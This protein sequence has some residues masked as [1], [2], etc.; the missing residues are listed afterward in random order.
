MN[1]IKN[2]II[3]ESNYDHNICLFKM[4]NSWIGDEEWTIKIKNKL[5]KLSNKSLNK[6]LEYDIDFNYLKTDKSLYHVSLKSRFGEHLLWDVYMSNNQCQHSEIKKLYFN[7]IDN[8]FK[9]LFLIAKPYVIFNNV[10]LQDNINFKLEKDRVNKLDFLIIKLNNDYSHA[11]INEIEYGLCERLRFVLKLGDYVLDDTNHVKD[12]MFDKFNSQNIHMHDEIFENE[13]F[14]SKFNN[15]IFI[16]LNKIYD[17]S[18]KIDVNT[19]EKN[20]M[21]SLTLDISIEFN[22][23]IIIDELNIYS[24]KVNL[25]KNIID[26]IEFFLL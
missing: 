8:L 24:K 15:Y 10:K 17:E 14:I 9:K 25:D 23:N 5:L 12:T 4:I 21:E 2:S 19:L 6:N 13:K 22:K 7:N 18:N 20:I 26:T 11:F 16:K 3:P 1:R